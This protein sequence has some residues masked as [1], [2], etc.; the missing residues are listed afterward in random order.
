[1]VPEAIECVPNNLHKWSHCTSTA[2]LQTSLQRS[3]QHFCISSMV[4][5]PWN[6][7]KAP[8]QYI[9]NSTHQ[10]MEHTCRNVYLRDFPWDNIP[11]HPQAG[12]QLR[13]MCGWQR[14][15][16]RD[17]TLHSY[18]KWNIVNWARKFKQTNIIMHNELYICISP[19]LKCRPRCY[20]G[21]SAV[22]RASTNQMQGNCSNS[23]GKSCSTV[24]S[25]K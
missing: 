15:H 11:W 17:H 24:F 7:S 21:S 4:F 20:V 14:K 6:S 18:A 22:Q 23:N 5:E 8:A 25:L 12:K 19:M 3:L 2:L 1:M 16:K 9:G 13:H 10:K